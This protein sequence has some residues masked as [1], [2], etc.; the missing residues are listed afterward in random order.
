[1]YIDPMRFIKRMTSEPIFDANDPLR[2]SPRVEQIFVE[3]RANGQEPLDEMRKVREFLEEQ[4]AE[5]KDLKRPYDERKILSKKTYK[6]VGTFG[7]W[8]Y[9]HVTVKRIIGAIVAMRM[10]Q[11]LCGA[12]TVY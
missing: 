1:M 9:L 12:G 10:E 4:I 3:L 5:R 8:V 11:G 6:K 7:W 2:L